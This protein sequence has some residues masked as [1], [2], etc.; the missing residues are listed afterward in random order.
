MAE[1]RNRYPAL[2]MILRE[3]LRSKRRRSSKSIIRSGTTA[4]TEDLSIDNRRLYCLKQ[5]QWCTREVVKVK[6]KVHTWEDA[7]QQQQQQKQ[8][9]Q[10]LCY[11]TRAA[12][13]QDVRHEETAGLGRCCLRN[14]NSSNSSSNSMRKSMSKSIRSKRRRRSK[15]SIRSGTTAETEESW[16][17]EDGRPIHLYQSSR[18]EL[19]SHPDDASDDVICIVGSVE[20]LRALLV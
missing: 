14:M 6:L 19:G 7:H 1:L 18:Q 9:E 5:Y 15:S 2:C 17:T 3:T 16:T 8:Q 13:R 11:V 4:E 20:T 12:H 10:A